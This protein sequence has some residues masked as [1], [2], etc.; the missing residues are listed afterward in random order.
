LS[1][2]QLLGVIALALCKIVG[3]DPNAECDPAVLL[4]NASSLNQLNDK[5]KLQA[6]AALILNWGIDNDYIVS[7]TDLRSDISCLMCLD[8]AKILSIILQLICTGVA[9]GTILCAV[10]N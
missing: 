7:E 3:A 10:R 2:K 4:E 1:T 8:D 6:L 5:Q 9:D